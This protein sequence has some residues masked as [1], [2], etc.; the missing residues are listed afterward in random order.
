MLSFKEIIWQISRQI[1]LGEMYSY[2]YIKGYN[3]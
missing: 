1:H 2:V 3:D